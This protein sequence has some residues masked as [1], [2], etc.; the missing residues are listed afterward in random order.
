MENNRDDLG[1]IFAGYKDRNGCLLSVPTRPVSRWPTNIDFPTTAQ[2]SAGDCQMNHGG[3]KSYRFTPRPVLAFADY[4]QRRN[5]AA[6]FA[7]ARSIRNEGLLCG[8]PP[9]QP[10]RSGLTK[11][12]SDHNRGRRHSPPAGSFQWRSQKGS[13]PASPPEVRVS[14]GGGSRSEAIAHLLHWRARDGSIRPASSRS[15]H[16]ITSPWLWSLP[17]RHHHRAGFD[18]C[19]GGSRLACPICRAW[20]NSPFW[21]LLLRHLFNAMRNLGPRFLDHLL[22]GPTTSCRKDEHAPP[23]PPSSLVR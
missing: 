14:G 12:E 4:I 10:P 2:R 20:L 9:V 6:F 8:N 23:I 22:G 7:N 5:A 21:R 16:G 18:R 1:V 17:R 15:A 19:S 3:P 13:T 11:G